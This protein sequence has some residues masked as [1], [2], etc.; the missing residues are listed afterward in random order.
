MNGNIKN[1][2]NQGKNILEI[3]KIPNPQLDSEVLLCNSINKKKEFIIFNQKKT[4][5][6]DQLKKFNAVGY[7]YN[8]SLSNSNE[9]LFIK[10]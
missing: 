5:D 3:N 10:N 4:L 9:L 8:E 6:S 1:I 7:I 2:L